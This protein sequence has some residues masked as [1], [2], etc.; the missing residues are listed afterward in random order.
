MAPKRAS[1]LGVALGATLSER[2]GFERKRYAYPDLSK[3]YQTTQKAMCVWF[4]GQIRWEGGS[5]ALDRAQIEED[6]AKVK[7]DGQGFEMDFRRA[8]SPLLEIVSV[9]APMWPDEAARALKAL[10]R[11]GVHSGATQGRIEEGHFKS[12]INISMR[13][14][15]AQ[16]LGERVEVKGV[17]SFDFARLAAVDVGRRAFGRR[18]LP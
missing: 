15:S 7:C 4:G 18:A 5:L 12:D 16:G 6:A 2:F 1:E 11:E 3:G 8:G 9:A 14:R 17:G 13:P 10:W